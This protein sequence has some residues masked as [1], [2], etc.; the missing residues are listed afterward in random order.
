MKRKL[1]L[2]FRTLVASVALVV[3]IVSSVV[4]YNKQAHN[5]H[6]EE[7]MKLER[8]QAQVGTELGVLRLR[9]ETRAVFRPKWQRDGT[10]PPAGWKRK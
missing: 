9:P 6:C 2:L 3:I 8:M 7:V 1:L 5:R 4:V 10:P